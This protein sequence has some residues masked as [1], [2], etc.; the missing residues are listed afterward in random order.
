MTDEEIESV[1]RFICSQFGL[2]PDEQV[3]CGWKDDLTPA[4]LASSDG[5]YVPDAMVSLPQWRVYRAKAALSL[6]ATIRQQGEE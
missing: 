4:E 3:Y 6:A 5:D 2:D 1:A